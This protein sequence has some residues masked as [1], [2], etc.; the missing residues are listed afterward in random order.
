MILGRNPALWLAVV[1]AALNV[2]V[3][4]L[5]LQL[6]AEQLAA[7]NA[8]AVALVG[9]VANEKDPTT[10]PTFALATGD[11][12]AAAPGSSSSAAAS[13]STAG[14]AATGSPSGPGA[15]AGGSAP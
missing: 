7:L 10:L 12:R 13:S 4:V 2:A 1:A 11:R 6:T 9:F 15:G 5:G 14:G 8:L 3:I